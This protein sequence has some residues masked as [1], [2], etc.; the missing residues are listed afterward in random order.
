MR[1]TDF[2]PNR[3]EAAK[4]AAKAFV[5]RQPDGI[6]IGVVA[7]SDSGF[8]VQEP[9]GERDEINAA[10]D[11]LAPERGTALGQGILSSLTAIELALHG[12]DTNYY[13]NRSPEPTP[14]PTPVP[15]GTW[16]P[17]AIVLL[18]DGE[19][20][21]EPDPMEVAGLARVR[22]VRIHTVGI[23]SP[24]G[25]VLEIE[26]FRVHSRLNQPLL[27][28]IAQVTGGSYYAADTTGELEAIYAG[29]DTRLVMRPETIEA[30]AIMVGA[31]IAV[32]MAGAAMSLL[33]LGRWP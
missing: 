17:A 25:A 3:M 28:Q 31:G 11:R 32:L 33:L 29:L 18:T 23:G 20:N 1:A 15:A 10:I 12:P 27:E 8:S 21:E 6:V 26:G 30:T 4:A 24:E 9:T 2:E 14:E 19:N 16:A 13:S 22:G 7:F 5:E